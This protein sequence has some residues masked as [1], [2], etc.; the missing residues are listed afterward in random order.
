MSRRNIS[1]EFKAEAVQLVVAQGYSF[2]K[3]C[4]ALGVGDTAL[5]RWVAQWRAEQAEPPSSSRKWIAPR[6]DPFAEEG[7]A[8][9][10]DVPVA[11]G[12]AKQLLRLCRAARQGRC[13]THPARGSA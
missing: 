1:D 4:E 10:C 6:S 2:A 7:L 11:E 9:E 12:A 3:A 8:S 13:F 5:R